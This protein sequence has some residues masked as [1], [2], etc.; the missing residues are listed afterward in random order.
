ML[1]VG[2]LGPTGYSGAQLLNILLRHPKAQIVYLGSRRETRPAIS[3]IWPILRGRIDMRCALLDADP[4]PQMDAA[5]LCLPHAAAMA[6]VPKLLAAGAKVIDLSA[7]YRLKDAAEY[8]RW[9]KVDHTDA[10]NLPKAVYGLT[11]LFREQVS[12]AVLLAN[13]GCYPTAVECAVA[14]MLARKLAG[15]GTIIVDAKSG[16]SGAGRDPKPD[17]HFPE[18]NESVSAYKVGVHQHA[19]EMTQTLSQIAGRKV[20]LLFVPHLIPMDRGILAT[21]YVPLAAETDAKALATVY[22]EFYK[23][24]PFI[25]VRSDDS[26]PT[27]KQVFDTNFCD[28]AVR[29]SGKT[30]IVISVIDNLIKGAAGQAVQNMNVM[31]GMDETLGLL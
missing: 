8:K 10:A 20:D 12:K 19:G 2:V 30:A 16:I 31:F 11:E 25:R 18:A 23:G 29:V 17:L 7:D 26:L 9:Y 27:T 1:R 21:C 4:L 14:P 28:I 22:A 24:C 5:F 13:P 3:D 6:N 15:A